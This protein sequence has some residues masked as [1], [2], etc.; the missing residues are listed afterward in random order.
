MTGVYHHWLIPR[1]FL[2]YEVPLFKSFIHFTLWLQSLVHRGGWDPFWVENSSSCHLATNILTWDLDRDFCKS[3]LWKSVV[4]NALWKWDWIEPHLIESV[5]ENGK[6]C[7]PTVKVF[8][9]SL[10][11]LF[12]SLEWG[13][14]GGELHR[15]MLYCCDA[16]WSI[17]KQCDKNRECIRYVTNDDS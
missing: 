11:L 7:G 6:P 15:Q 10:C 16:G 1:I 9:L 12:I 2:L 4:K 8:S 3:A 17:T 13:I 5:S 14:V